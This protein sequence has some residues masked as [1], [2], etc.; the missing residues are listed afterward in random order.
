PW[1]ICLRGS[2]CSVWSVRKRAPRVRARAR[3]VTSAKAG[4]AIWSIYSSSSSVD[5]CV[6]VVPGAI[7]IGAPVGVID[8]VPVIRW[9]VPAGAPHR[10]TPTDHHP[11]VAG[12]CRVGDPVVTVILVWLHG[13]VGDAV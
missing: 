6:R 4:A 3:V 1:V 8:P 12:V 13:D 7:A 5:T 2:A 10:A 9:V 11:A